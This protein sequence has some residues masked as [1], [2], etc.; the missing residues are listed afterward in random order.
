[1]DEEWAFVNDGTGGYGIVLHTDK[2]P[3]ILKDLGYTEVPKSH[4]IPLLPEQAHHQGLLKDPSLIP[5]GRQ[6]VYKYFTERGWIIRDGATYGVDY[7]L[8]AGPPGQ[9]HSKYGV[10]INNTTTGETL[11]W[12][13]FAGIARTVYNAK[14]ELLVVRCDNSSVQ[15]VLKVDR[16]QPE[17]LNKTK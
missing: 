7:L 6:I 16:F 14:K 2:V 3:Q 5:I 10:L 9:V 1:M 17:L 12:R 11:K 13:H 4:I 8:Y 15:S